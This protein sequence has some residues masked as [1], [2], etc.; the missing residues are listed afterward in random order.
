MAYSIQVYVYSKPF[1]GFIERSA[2]AKDGIIK[3]I[4]AAAINNQMINTGSVNGFE[5][6]GPTSV[7]A[8][9][10]LHKGDKQPSR[11]DQLA[12]YTESSPPMYQGPG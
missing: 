10:T 3:K 12:S 4:A 6:R 9:V 11:L 7:K 1:H 5:G 2:F 8:P